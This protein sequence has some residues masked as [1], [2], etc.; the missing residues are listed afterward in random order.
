MTVAVRYFSRSGRT[1]RIANAFAV[2]KKTDEAKAFGKALAR[3]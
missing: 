2:D 3:K 1:R